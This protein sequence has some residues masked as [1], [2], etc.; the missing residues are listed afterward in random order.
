MMVRDDW[1]LIKVKLKIL[2]RDTF[3]YKNS[4]KYLRVQRLVNFE[5]VKEEILLKKKNEVNIYSLS[6]RPSK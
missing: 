5:I 4:K 2:I 6:I 1:F 3:F